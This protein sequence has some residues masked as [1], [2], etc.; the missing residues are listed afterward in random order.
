MLAIA[1]AAVLVIGWAM[2][3]FVP[4]LGCVRSQAWPKPLIA[5]HVVSDALVA[6]AYIVIPAVLIWIYTK[7]KAR[8]EAKLLYLF[9]AFIVLCGLT[10][11]D[12]II[13]IWLPAYWFTGAVKLATGL[14]S[15]ATAVTLTVLAPQ[16]LGLGSLAVDL[17]KAK[18]EA[19]R[20]RKAAEARA[21]RAEGDVTELE[22]AQAALKA[23]LAKA[24][25]AKEREAAARARAEEEKARAE[26]LGRDAL[27]SARIAE[28]ARTQAEAA[29]SEK[30][31]VQR[32]VKDLSTPILP[33][34]E[35]IAAMPLIGA[36]DSMRAAQAM[37]TAT[38]YV[39][40]NAV[41]FLLLD[42][43]GVP[44]V[45]TQVASAL[46][47][48]IQ[49]VGLIGGTCIVTGIRPPVAQTMVD[50]GI[51]MSSVTTRSTLRAGLTAAMAMAKA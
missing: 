16:I 2:G 29:I 33:L 10:H 51:D 40:L 30:L 50:L 27:E 18:D 26:R 31:A 24:E 11:I 25:D 9:G 45:D 46:L 39:S 36:L 13:A 42:L 44:V 49:A 41:R 43:S 47:K 5:L 7:L 15:I 4:V 12:D 14:V 21:T 1:L 8:P 34:T 37:D 23:A 22:Q 17:Q 48:T 19:D 32:A 38:E 20:L 6:I 28:A 3:I 35:D